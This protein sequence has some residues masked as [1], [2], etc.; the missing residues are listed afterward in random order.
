[1]SEALKPVL[2]RRSCRQ[3]T[4]QPVSD[5]ALHTLLMAGMV[6]PSAKN[7]Q[8][9]EF[10]VLRDEALKAAVSLVG[11]HW[12]MLKDAPL[13]IMVLANLEG[14]RAPQTEYF[15][16]DCSAATENI[17]VAAHAMGLGAVWLG[18]YPDEERVKGVRQL[19][20]IPED[21]VPVTLMAIG[22]PAQMPHPHTT[23]KDDKVHY[24]RY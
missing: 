6:A 23:F 8:P 12:G 16:Q 11:P 18:L 22:H 3:Y 5:E 2:E 10:I 24:D 17:L 13:G 7:S 4:A 1:M 21:I 14:Y 9:W 19:C 20:G 15:V